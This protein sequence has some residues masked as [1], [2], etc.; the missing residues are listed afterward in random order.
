MKGCHLHNISSRQYVFLSLFS[1]VLLFFLN[2]PIAFALRSSHLIL[3]AA[4]VTVLFYERYHYSEYALL[5]VGVFIL[6]ISSLYYLG[7][8]GSCHIIPPESIKLFLLTGG[9]VFLHRHAGCSLHKS[10]EYIVPIAILAVFWNYLHASSWSYYDSAKMRYG[11]PML[12]SPNSTAY[13]LSFLTVTALVAAKR[14]PH[15]LKNLAWLLAALVLTS[16]IM[17]TQSR[18]GLVLLFLGLITLFRIDRYTVFIALS[19]LA[20]AILYI[21]PE[22]IQRLNVI[23]DIAST[24][25]TGRT[26]IWRQLIL[27]LLADPKALLLGYGPGNINVNIQ[28]SIATSAHS[29]FITLIYWFGLTGIALSLAYIGALLWKI[30]TTSNMLIKGF[31]VMLL[32][33][34]FIDSYLLDANILLVNAFLLA[35]VLLWSGDENELL[36]SSSVRIPK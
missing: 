35:Y 16:A 30:L 26:E 27:G 15:Y 21:N 22:Y 34:F 25:G 20:T 28:G 17:L 19:A 36:L 9:A 32:A 5:L 7:C 13:V 14:E 23:S 8:E 31:S 18:G 33:S 24:G 10:I 4:L 12:G 1:A 2:Y 29:G 11:I 6:V 3:I